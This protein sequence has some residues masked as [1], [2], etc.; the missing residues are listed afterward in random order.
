[1]EYDDHIVHNL[2]WDSFWVCVDSE[3][4]VHSDHIGAVQHYEGYLDDPENSSDYL[5]S[6]KP[7]YA[8]FATNVTTNHFDR[9]KPGNNWY[10]STM[11][12][13][14][15][16]LPYKAHMLTTSKKPESRG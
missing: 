7:L 15:K 12:D 14:A 9:D 1:M 11:L 2:N 4:T 13:R 3:L 10:F 8:L 6:P 5:E 16:E